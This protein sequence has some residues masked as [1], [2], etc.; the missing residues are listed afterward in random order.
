MNPIC[1]PVWTA[2]LHLPPPQSSAPAPLSI[3]PVS[4]L[5][6]TDK[7][8]RPTLVAWQ[9]MVS[10]PFAKRLAGTNEHYLAADLSDLALILLAIPQSSKDRKGQILLQT[11][12]CAGSCAGQ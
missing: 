10:Y 7:G 6:G 5:H 9:K 12:R 11:E 4:I 8:P 3:N 1:R 2:M